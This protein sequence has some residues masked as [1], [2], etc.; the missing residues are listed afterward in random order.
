MTEILGMKVNEIFPSTSQPI[1][2]IMVDKKVLL[3][4]TMEERNQKSFYLEITY[5]VEKVA[6]IITSLFRVLLHSR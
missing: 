6:L 4:S 2:G 1:R 3:L 5:K